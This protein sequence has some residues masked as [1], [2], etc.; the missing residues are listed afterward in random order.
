MG[1]GPLLHGIGLDP[2]LGDVV[3]PRFVRFVIIRLPRGVS[4]RTHI[5]FTEMPSEF[6]P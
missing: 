4:H 2:Y 6:D 1:G 3:G 5:H